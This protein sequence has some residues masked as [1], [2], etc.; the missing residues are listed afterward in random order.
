MLLQCYHA[1]LDCPHAGGLVVRD[2]SYCLSPDVR[3]NYQTSS[4]FLPIFVIT[5]FCE[6][7]NYK[8]LYHIV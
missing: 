2:G 1:L 3:W 5:N 6:M 7:M 4:S 8:S